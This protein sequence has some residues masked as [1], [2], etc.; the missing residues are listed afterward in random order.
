MSARVLSGAGVCM[1]MSTSFAELAQLSKGSSSNTS[2]ADRKKKHLVL[3]QSSPLASTRMLPLRIERSIRIGIMTLI[4]IR[5]EL[6]VLVQIYILIRIGIR[7]RIRI[8]LSESLL[9]LKGG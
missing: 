7:I 3:G 8:C 6:Q 9:W 1:H 5:I 4:H 2:I